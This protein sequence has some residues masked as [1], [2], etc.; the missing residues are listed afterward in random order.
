MSGIRQL[1][2]R[3]CA[4]RLVGLKSPVIFMHQRPDADTV[5]SAIALIRILRKL[6]IDAEYAS[7]DPISD[8]LSFL[9][10]GERKAEDFENRD[11]VAIDVASAAQLGELSQYADKIIL[12]IDHHRVNSPFSDNYTV[13]DASSAAEVLYEVLCELTDMG[14]ASLDDS[15]AYPM[16]AAISSDTGG[17]LFSSASARSY[18]LAA[19]LIETGIDFAD[20]NHRLF[21]SKSEGQIKA[22]GFIASKIATDADGKISYATLSRSELEESG[23]LHEHFETAID[24]VRSV[25][26]A[27]IAIFVRES[28][29][30]GVKASLRSTGYN[31]AEIAA[32][33]GGG[34]HIRAAGCALPTQSAGEGARLL[35]SE[36]KKTLK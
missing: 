25:I 33:F 34:G 31:V 16:Y 28:K 17:F 3:E 36:I 1:S 19:T 8:R 35:I 29:D 9:V 27:Q 21:H 12:T 22:E 14:K 30:G 32:K 7:A 24:I 6:G 13:A 23:L 5:G 10:E 18:R 11:L 15:I 2:A 4:E 26:H 20:I